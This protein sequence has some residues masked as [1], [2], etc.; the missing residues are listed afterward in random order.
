[1]EVSG[2]SASLPRSLGKQGLAQNLMNRR[3]GG[4]QTPDKVTAITSAA[5]GGKTPISQHVASQFTEL[6]RL[7][8]QP[9]KNKKTCNE[10]SLSAD[11]KSDKNGYRTAREQS[12]HYRTLHCV[13]G[14]SDEV[15]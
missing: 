11:I 14:L 9:R 6:H 10:E 8:T 3:L 12:F 7:F 13:A 2:H 5:A 4:P 1:M 15:L